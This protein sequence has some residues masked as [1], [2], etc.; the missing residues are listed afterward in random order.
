MGL[1]AFVS[2]DV[3]HNGKAEDAV[4]N[5]KNES[6]SEGN[7]VIAATE[8]TVVNMEYC[9]L[10]DLAG[11]IV[12]VNLEHLQKKNKITHAWVLTIHKFQGSEAETIVY[13]LSGS[14]NESW[15]HVYTAVTRG[16]K[17]VVIVGSFEDLKRA[18]KKKPI[19]RQTTLDEKVK[20]LLTKVEKMK[21]K[22][23]EE[24]NE[25][26]KMEVDNPGPSKMN[27]TSIKTYLSP[28]KPP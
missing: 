20:K 16:R 13:C 21:E 22:E 15:R 9:V 4:E 17:S 27:Q 19:Q 18:V 26:E 7:E 25:A 2:G 3:K 5:I 10:D 28:I 24:Q 1:R 23:K 14:N 8:G 12:R 6:N 11:E